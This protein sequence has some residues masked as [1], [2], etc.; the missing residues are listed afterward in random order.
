[1]DTDTL[2][3]SLEREREAR[4][5]VEIELEQK[6]QELQ[7]A[8]RTLTL[9]AEELSAKTLQLQAILDRTLAAILVVT[10][11]GMIE[12]ANRVAI[13]SFGLTPDTIYDTPVMMLFGRKCQA[14]IE[15]LI[16]HGSYEGD[17]NYQTVEIT[18]VR[19]DR[20]T[21]PIEVAVAKLEQGQDEHTVW[22]CRDITSRRDDERRRQVLETEIRQSQKLESLGTLASGI[23]HEINTPIQFIGDNLHFLKEAFADFDATLSATRALFEALEGEQ[24]ET[25]LA[26]L[27]QAE[28]N[29]DIGYLRGEIPNCIDQSLEG[30][31]RVSEIVGAIRAFA[32]PGS[33]EKT[34][35][36]I[37]KIVETTVTVSRSQWKYAA[38]MALE[39]D[40]GLPPVLAHPNDLH[41][42]LLNLIVNAADAIQARD[43]FKTGT[44][45][46]RTSL[47]PAFLV[48]AV[49][50][51]GCG[52]ALENQERIFDPFFTTKAVGK[53]TGQGLSIVYNIIVHKLGGSIDVTSQ[54]NE[55][56]TFTIKL[57]RGDDV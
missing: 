4:R 15:T 2:A 26:R 48:L 1:M 3:L 32:H 47:E 14:T 5:A 53:G 54:E 18:G 23:A 57:P 19:A 33:E 55:G 7:R 51:T 46:I 37:N 22:I 8:N 9:K 45:S 13:T 21:F 11:D 40:P 31:Q 39:L 10:G 30:V 35:V 56:T 42:V 38:E 36:D 34:P 49:S 27:E 16:E 41:Q 52:I 43:K 6:N 28:K 50:D 29:A 17:D 24:K 20:T 12:R 25:L 44:I